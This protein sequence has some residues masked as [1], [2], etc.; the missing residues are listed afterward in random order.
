MMSGSTNGQRGR[1]W[2]IA[3]IAV[4]VAGVLTVGACSHGGSHG[5]SRAGMGG[6]A[7]PERAAHTAEKMADR[8]VSRV[9][10]TP[11]QKQKITG[12]AQAAAQDLLPLR[13]QARAARVQSIA[14][15]RA[16]TVDRAAIEALRVDQVRLADVASRR[17]AEAIADAAEVLTPDQR[18]KLADRMAT[19]RGWRS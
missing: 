19:R 12:I 8:L 9:D 3:G 14:L 11:E 15:L 1:R 5:W 2:R 10:G 7:D 17:L 6:A 4:V 16:P 18:A 13:E